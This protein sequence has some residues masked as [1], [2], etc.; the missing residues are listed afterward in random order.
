VDPRRSL[1]LLRHRGGAAG[2]SARGGDRAGARDP[3]QPGEQG[4]RSAGARR[5]RAQGE[6]PAAA[7]PARPLR[8]RIAAR[9]E[10]G[11]DPGRDSTPRA[12]AHDT[13]GGALPPLRVEEAPGRLVTPPAV[14]RGGVG[15]RG[16]FLPGGFLSFTAKALAK[17]RRSPARRHPRPISR[18]A[19]VRGPASP[20]SKGARSRGQKKRAPF[21]AA[22]SNDRVPSADRTQSITRTW[23]TG[24]SL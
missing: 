24:E 15:R 20:R 19:S 22:R 10:G 13:P 1:A 21:G 16:P 11:R 14:T 12:G 23:K 2:R 5:F 18:G 6:R 7:C 3:G 4:A 8:R 9:S 17:N